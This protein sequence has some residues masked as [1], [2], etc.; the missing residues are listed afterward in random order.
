MQI[1]K[2]VYITDSTLISSD[3]PAANSLYPEWSSTTSYVT[4]QRVSVNYLEDGV[5]LGVHRIYECLW[6]TP[7][8]LNLYPPDHLGL[9]SG[10]YW[11]S[12]VSATERWK[13]FD[14]IV[15]PDRANASDNVIGTT[16]ESGVIWE[17]DTIWDSLTYSSMMITV[18]PGII[19][20]VAIMNID[21][22]SASVIMM[23]GA[24]E[25]YNETQIPSTATFNNLI[26]ED[27]PAYANAYVT[28]IIRNYS[29][30]INVG[31]IIFGL[32][33]TLGTVKYGVGVGLVDYS[34]K[35]ADDFG[36]FTVLERSFTKR[37]D[38][39]VMIPMASHSGV[40]RLL[41]NYR[42]TPLVWIVSDLYSTTMTY[43]YY[44]DF[45]ISLPNPTTAECGI[46]IE[47]LGGDHINITPP[48]NPWVDPWDG[49]IRLTVPGMPTVGI[50][51]VTKIEEAPVIKDITGL[52]VPAV[53]TMAV[54]STVFELV[55]TCTISHAEPA[56]VT[57]A[58]HGL[59]EDR[60]VIFQT[61]GSLPLPLVALTHY[62]VIYIDVD[63]FQL[64]LTI[65][66]SPVD[67]TTDGSGTHKLLAK[68]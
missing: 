42:S 48:D 3:I 56:V 6:H 50:P 34:V 59:A 31:E 39:T 63:T 16:W 18:M 10:H 66:G 22:S 32:L 47:G 55:G 25:V 40:M 62:F 44:R 64:S 36:G 26:F 58:G 67:T 2:P 30:D 68:A 29:G 1:I 37:L 7:A 33:K 8:N 21:C 53:P 35:Q 60:E 41:E 49:I 45:E 13:L 38:C 46:S 27:L 14:L 57:K 51:T 17:P 54:S 5:T 4:G 28:V 24:T 11:W 15:A 43:G 9:E 52:T 20:S 65:A 23:N 12:R 61:T 19:D